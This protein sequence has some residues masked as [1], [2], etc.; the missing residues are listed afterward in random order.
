MN[1]TNRFVYVI[2]Y[3]ACW[4]FTRAQ[5]RALCV[6]AAKGEG[7]DLDAA[8]GKELARLPTYWRE[9]SDVVRPLDWNAEDFAF[10]A[11]QEIAQ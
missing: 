1:T 10:A 9:R 11:T 8:G 2:Q 6:E 7:Y 4:R 3:N 5:W